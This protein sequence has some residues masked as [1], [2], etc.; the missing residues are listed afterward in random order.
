MQRTIPPTHIPKTD[1]LILV[2][3][4]NGPIQ[5]RTRLEKILFLVKKEVLDRLKRP[6]ASS[7]YLFSPY[8]FGPFS[9]DLYDDV[10][11]LRD[12]GFIEV[13]GESGGETFSITPKG[14]Q[15]LEAKL[16]KRLPPEVTEEVIRVGSKY[17]KLTIQDLIKYV[18]VRYPEYA[19][20]SE[21]RGEVIGKGL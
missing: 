14:S 6:E 4:S 15:F 5:G 3:G 21:I 2:I 17:A 11:F 13:K 12:N 8:R 10:E 18:Y 9:E 1:Y 7:F 16:K 19:I 20:Q